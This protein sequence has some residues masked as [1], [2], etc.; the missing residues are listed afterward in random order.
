MKSIVELINELNEMDNVDAARRF[1][2]PTV[3]VAYYT[4][5]DFDHWLRNCLKPGQTFEDLDHAWELYE[6][7][8][9]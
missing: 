4:K 8:F 7:S 5:L 1:D 9:G 6:K 2:L 3:D